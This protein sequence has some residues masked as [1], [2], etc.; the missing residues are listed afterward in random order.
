[1]YADP[2]VLYREML[3]QLPH[4]G[5][6]GGTVRLAGIPLKLSST[7]GS[8]QRHPPRLGEHTHEI[9]AELGYEPH[10]VHDLIAAGVAGAPP[11]TSA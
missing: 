1:V 11:R 5:L 7:P 3:Q 4:P 2:Q 9:L 10:E 8:P 6:A